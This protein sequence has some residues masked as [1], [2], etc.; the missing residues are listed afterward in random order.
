[1]SNRAAKVVAKE[2]GSEKV[3]QF[4]VHKERVRKKKNED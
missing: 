4:I 1:M 2:T 3:K